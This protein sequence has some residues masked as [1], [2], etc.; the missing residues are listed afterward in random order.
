MHV[1]ATDAGFKPLRDRDEE[2]IADEMSQAVIHGLEA[3][4]VD[5]Q[6][7]EQPVGGPFRPGQRLLEHLHEERAIGERRERVVQ[8]GLPKLLL[9]QMTF[10]DVGQRSRHAHRLGHRRS[11]TTTPRQSAHR[12]S[13]SR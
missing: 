13:P 6:D 7:A 4:H 8:G 11:V 12:Y 10:G 9:D 2:L 5:E 1:A 3:V